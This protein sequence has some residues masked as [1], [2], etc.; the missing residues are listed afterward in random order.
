MRGSLTRMTS[1]QTTWTVD[2]LDSW[3]PGQPPPTWTDS[4]L[5]VTNRNCRKLAIVRE[6]YKSAL[7]LNL[8]ENW[9]LSCVRNQNTMLHSICTGDNGMTLT[10]IIIMK[11]ATTIRSC[12]RW[13]VDDVILRTSSLVSSLLYSTNPP[14][15]QQI[16]PT[17]ANISTAPQEISCRERQTFF[18]K[19]RQG[20]CFQV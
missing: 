18:Q 20:P 8:M 9:K 16:K 4:V 7:S 2:H 12:W 13:E 11:L 10:M 19:T 6:K 17:A 15:T 14:P 3:P 1:Y 5:L